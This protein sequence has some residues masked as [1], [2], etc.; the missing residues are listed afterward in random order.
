MTDLDYT[1]LDP[2]IRGAVQ[3]LRERG[4][5]TTDSGDGESK[6]ADERVFS[7][8]HV[9]ISTTGGSLVEECKRLVSALDAINVKTIPQSEEGTDF[10]AGEVTIQGTYDPVADPAQKRG[11][12]VV[13]GEGLRNIEPPPA[14][15][16]TMYLVNDDG[17]RHFVSAR[18]EEDARRVYAEEEVGAASL[19]ECR[20]EAW[21]DRVSIHP[22]KPDEVLTFFSEDARTAEQW[23]AV[24]RGVLE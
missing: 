20:N 4:F 16:L 19:D 23:A 10:D 5:E 11:L 8:P 3:Y 1:I 7:C 17:V 24:G 2:G 6:P 15:R 14:E 22:F 21:W 12:I 18:D 13:W 9:A